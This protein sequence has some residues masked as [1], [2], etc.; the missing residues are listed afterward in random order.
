MSWED[1]DYGRSGFGRPGGDW[2]GVRPTLD[3][4]MSWS[5]WIGRYFGV[6]V[7][8]HL[9]LILFVVIEI[10][11]AGLTESGG[12][13]LY[14][15]SI[16]VLALFTIVLLHEFGHIFA[17]R[18]TGGEA[19]EILMWPLGGLAYC[20]PPD[21]WTAHLW[22]VLGGPLVNAI[23][24]IAFALVLGLTQKVWLGV[25]IPNPFDRAPAAWFLDAQTP[26]WARILHMIA[27][28]NLI[29]LLF[30]VLLPLFPLDGGRILQALLWPKLGYIRSMRIAVR[31]GYFG[32]IAL[33]ILGFLMLRA[34]EYQVSGGLLIVIAL[35]G[36]LTCWTT[37][38]QLEFAEEVMGFSYDEYALTMGKAADKDEAT[39]RGPSP[40]AL[41]KEQ[42]RA[43]QEAHD[44]A[45]LD[46]LLQKIAEKGM[47]QLTGRERKWLEQQ[48]KKKREEKS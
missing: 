15:T 20:R 28:V 48:T 35:F 39:A 21:R 44:A 18:M 25:A 36:G 6:D 10:L 1:R 45:E 37:H 14:Y 2:K 22:T 42:R 5:L 38:K 8:L 19:D 23:L 41:R 3:N 43:E 9:M 24:L 30:N 34:E 11:Q 47:D 13:Q 32:A 26:E 33:G 40:R 7:R 31:V 17:C 46:R 16:S 12:F 29:L 4:P 27:W